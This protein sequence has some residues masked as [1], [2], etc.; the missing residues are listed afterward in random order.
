MSRICQIESGIIFQIFCLKLVKKQATKHLKCFRITLIQ[1]SFFGFLLNRSCLLMILILIVR[2]SQVSQVTLD[3]R[4]D[5]K[6]KSHSLNEWKGHLTSRNSK[7]GE[8]GE[9]VLPPVL[10]FDQK[11][12]AY[13]DFR[14]F[15]G[16][17]CILNR[18]ICI[19]TSLMS[20]KY[21]YANI[22]FLH[23]CY[24]AVLDKMPK[25]MFSLLIYPPPHNA[26]ENYIYK[27]NPRP[28]HL[29]LLALFAHLGWYLPT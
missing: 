23:V 24:R 2:R 3:C 11:K 4:E 6:I 16:I 14:W 15:V 17:F 25:D 29:L 5:S 28:L 19:F 13:A 27:Q 9:P 10:L 20:R 7:N 12:R 1:V 21:I 26:Y 22:R 8:L 18:I